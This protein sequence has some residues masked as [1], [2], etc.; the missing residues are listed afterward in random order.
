M[1]TAVVKASKKVLKKLSAVRA[2]LPKDEREVLDAMV[3][4][5]VAAHSF[6]GKIG[7]KAARSGKA[8]AHSFGGKIGGKAAKSG[9]ASAHQAINA[10][11]QPQTTL[12]PVEF[13]PNLEVY[14]PAEN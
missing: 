10:P 13:D 5:E 1:K 6:G 2:V 9:K 4:G 11:T 12:P 8:A 7:G 3:L 14:Q